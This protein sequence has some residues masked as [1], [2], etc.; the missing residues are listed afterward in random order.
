MDETE[1]LKIINE[2]YAASYWPFLGLNLSGVKQIE[3]DRFYALPEDPESN[4]I[5]LFPP[6]DVMVESCKD[7]D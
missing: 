2:T 5:I 1:L 7:G 6:V 3:D 4:I